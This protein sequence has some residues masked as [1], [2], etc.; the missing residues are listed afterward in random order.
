MLH[1]LKQLSEQLLNPDQL[2]R[3]RY[4]TFKGML[5]S[6]RQAHHLLAEIE[7]IYYAGK[8]VDIARLR[9]L[10]SDLAAAV[11]AMIDSLRDLA[12]GKYRNLEAYHKKIDF[13]IR[14]AL[15]PP[16]TDRSPPYVLPLEGPYEDDSR[17]GGKAFHLSRLKGLLGLPV[18]EGFILSTSAWNEVVEINGLRDDIDR[19][20]A[21]VDIDSLPSLE[22]ASA[23]LHE[24]I[25][26][27]RLPDGVE[28]EIVRRAEEIGRRTGVDDFAVRS[29]CVAEDS[30]LSFAGQY[31][32]LLNVSV[33]DIAASCLRIYA[34]KYTPEAI[35][36][37]ILNGLDDRA[38][39]MGVLILTM[40]RA[41]VSGAAVVTRCE[42][43]TLGIAVHQV[44][45]LGDRLMSGE[46]TPHITEMQVSESSGVNLLD[47]S[48]SNSRLD[49]AVL[50]Q[51]ALYGEKIYRD[52]GQEQEIE[53]SF[54]QQEFLYLLQARALTS[55]PAA[56]RQNDEIDLSQLVPLFSGGETGS[57]GIGCGNVFHLEGAHQSAEIPVGIIMVSEITPP[58]LV[59]LL[60]HLNGVIARQGSAA[61]HFSS[62]AREFAVPVLL[63]AGTAIDK[64]KGEHEI[65]VDAGRKTV[66]RGSI[67]LPETLQT[68]TQL[69]PESPVGSALKMV[70]N[71]VSPLKL[72]DPQAAD[73]TPENCRSMHD[74]IRFV[75]EK[76]VKAMFLH[77][78]DSFFRKPSTVELVSGIPLQIYLVDVGGGLK[79]QRP[80][81]LQAAVEDI[82]SIPMKHLWRGLSHPGVNWK[83]HSHFDWASYDSIALAGG[84]AGSKSAELASYCLLS[85]D[86]VNINM[87][88][89][90]HFTLLDCLCGEVPEENYILMRFAGGGGTD[91]GKD[92]RLLFIIEILEQLGFTCVRTGDLLDAR[93]L[94]YDRD[95]TGDRINQVGR[96]LGCVRLL[97]MVLRSEDEVPRLVEKFFAGVYDYANQ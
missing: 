67:E 60:P 5:N 2:I 14:F 20:L 96:L 94:R 91:I 1:L 38:V 51:L 3:K 39:P 64:L 48:S 10:L 79:E 83:D 4:T 33:E 89:G 32:S 22:R 37:R 42:D 86:Y 74:I 6:D 63:Q 18:P 25:L 56:A 58:S 31:L 70:V 27:C 92:L 57:P 43:R 59:S 71:F 65:V 54:D 12:P 29:S 90:Y 69:A 82:V 11:E 30:E 88:F 75:H 84:V 23:R 17:V 21:E 95:Q 35:L 80:G 15:A 16:E 45:G 24:R 55:P 46:T 68:K 9:I 50:R 85:G 13:Y 62:V 47:D 78:P 76:G 41:R 61:D 7:K 87:R 8:A 81:K 66:Y 97:D 72:V 53:W 40:V 93:L 52:C 19:E 34:S 49:D 44:S 28:Q 36:Y 77:S 26:N 73:F